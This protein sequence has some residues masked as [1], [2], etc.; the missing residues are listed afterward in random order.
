MTTTASSTVKPSASQD[1]G[2]AKTLYEQ[3]MKL[4][5]SGRI[6]A[7]AEKLESAYQADPENEEVA[8]KLAYYADLL[9]D[10]EL[11]LAIYE[12]MAQRQPTREGVLLNL[13]VLYEDLGF[14][15]DADPP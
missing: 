8:F 6:E 3:A 1:A 10:D 15:N 9:G 2:K 11:S 4:A 5:H 12:T 14:Y 13:S 7:A